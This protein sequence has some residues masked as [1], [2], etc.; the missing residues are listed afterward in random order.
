MAIQ[1]PLLGMVFQAV[2]ETITIKGVLQNIQTGALYS[3][4]FSGVI[5]SSQT[6]TLVDIYTGSYPSTS[7]GGFITIEGGSA[8]V[9][10]GAVNGVASGSVVSALVVPPGAYA[11]GKLARNGFIESIGSAYSFTENVSGAVSGAHP[12]LFN[13]TRITGTISTAAS[14]LTFSNPLSHRYGF[15]FTNCSSAPIRIGINSPPTS[16]AW[17][18]SCPAEGTLSLAGIGKFNTIY[19]LGVTSNQ[20]WSAMEFA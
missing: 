15:I 10:F 18:Y 13:S 14:A 5:S 16:S 4:N 17:E 2:S 20:A 7:T 9:G 8:R 3:T 12:F 19:L 1:S 11:I 6:K